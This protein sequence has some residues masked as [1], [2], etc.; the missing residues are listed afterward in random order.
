MTQKSYVI[1]WSL[2]L[3]SLFNGGDIMPYKNLPVILTPK[4]VQDILC[5]SKDKVYRL[6]RSRTFP[7]EKVSGKYI[8]PKPRFLNWLGIKEDE[9]ECI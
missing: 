3:F 7:S 8:I 4:D 9:S 1:Y 2:I 5:W 6:F